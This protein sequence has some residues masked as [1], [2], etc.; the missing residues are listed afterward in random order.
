MF[1]IIKFIPLI[2]IMNFVSAQNCADDP[3][4]A[5]PA[6]CDMVVNAWGMSCDAELSEYIIGEGCP[7]TC[8]TCS[9]GPSGCDLP[10]MSL[11]ILEDGS[12]LYN[13]S[14]SIGKIVV[15]IFY[16]LPKQHI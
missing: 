9:T 14:S 12:V 10:V 5:L 11:S 15:F 6:S 13:T 8:G 4:G 2:L 3:T 1:N 16:L 7:V